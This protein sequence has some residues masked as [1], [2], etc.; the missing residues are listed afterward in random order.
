MRPLKFTLFRTFKNIVID[1][2]VQKCV[3]GKEKS[4]GIMILMIF[5]SDRKNDG[6][7]LVMS[8]INLLNAS[9]LD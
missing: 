9:K 3:F 4:F 5:G 1:L 6:I 8:K 7:P 2:M